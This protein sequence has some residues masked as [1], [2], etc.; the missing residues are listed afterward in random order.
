MTLEHLSYDDRLEY[1]LLI[2]I[3]L[4]VFVSL[5]VFLLIMVSRIRHIALGYKKE[6]LLPIYEGIINAVLFEQKDFIEE[7]RA[8]PGLLKGSFS[9]KVLMDELIKLHNHFSGEYA[10]ALVAIYYESGLIHDSY[11]KLNSLRWHIVCKGI[12]ELS[13][14]QVK[15]AYQPILKHARSWHATLRQETQLALLNLKGFKGLD[16]LNRLQA[17]LND[18]EQLNLIAVLDRM[19]KAEMPDFTKWLDSKNNSVIVFTLRLIIHFNQIT[20][21]EKLGTFLS[22]SDERIRLT[23]IKAVKKLQAQ[24]YVPLLKARYWLEDVS[25][26]I[27][28]LEAMTTL[29][30][31]EDIS[32]LSQQLSSHDHALRLK[33]TQAL[34]M[35]LLNKETFFTP[36]FIEEH[37][38]QQ[39]IEHLTDKRIHA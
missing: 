33:A 2:M 18:W 14:M 32:F 23:A 10:D 20:A 29:G 22:H 25:L 17:E 21:V 27:E 15:E 12:K 28:I 16:F 5:F 8:Y 1:F 24:E 38:L 35:V 30:S 37:G 13:Q 6:S 11:K 34:F 26:Q 3:A 36:A 7:L 39:I 31:E 9:R 4:F 19:E